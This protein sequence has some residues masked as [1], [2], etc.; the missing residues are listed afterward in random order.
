MN[1]YLRAALLMCTTLGISCGGPDGAPNSEP[2][3]LRAQ[4]SPC[5]LAC[6]NL[7]E[8]CFGIDP[9]PHEQCVA[10]CSSAT[11]DAACLRQAVS[12]NGAR[13]CELDFVTTALGGAPGDRLLGESCSSNFYCQSGY[14]SGREC[15]E[16]NLDDSCDRDSGCKS[17]ACRA[18]KCSDGS[19]HASCNVDGDCQSSHC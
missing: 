12:C 3:P 11:G 17:G 19:L 16:G 1:R 15:S 8:L 7:E 5:Q 10:G 13:Q 4:L 9:F 18:G 2:N 14:C 6:Q